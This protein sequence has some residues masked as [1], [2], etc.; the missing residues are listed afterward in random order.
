VEQLRAQ[1][2]D[3]GER[4][5]RALLGVWWWRWGH[6]REALDAAF[7]PHLSLFLDLLP[8]SAPWGMYWLLCIVQHLAPPAGEV[9]PILLGLLDHFRSDSPE[10]VQRRQHLLGALGK[11]G[12]PSDADLDRIAEIARRDKGARWHAILCLG[13]AART[14]PRAVELLLEFLDYR[15]D[16]NYSAGRVLGELRHKARP[17]LPRLI[18]LVQGRDPAW[19]VGALDAIANMRKLAAAAAPAV[20]AAARD[21]DKAVRTKALYALSQLGPEV[22]GALRAAR[23]ALDEPDREIRESAL[24]AMNWLTRPSEEARAVVRDMLRHADSQV[25]RFALFRMVDTGFDLPEVLARLEGEIGHRTAE[26]RREAVEALG[27]VHDVDRYR[28]YQRQHRPA[29][30]GDRKDVRPRAPATV[31]LLRRALE[32]RDSSVRYAAVQALGKLGAAARAAVPRL[33]KLTE[34][35]DVLVEYAA[36]AALK[37]IEAA[38]E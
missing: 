23:E 36:R 26:R 4:V 21:P 35:T 37:K 30:L 38:S 8:R 20:L 11:I 6:P 15:C 12:L 18:E 13:A 3:L 9:G 17:A 24:Q 2:P 19:R 5:G 16:I 14:Y 33:R 22:E 10:E 34:D 7:R 27:F 32:D 1:P 25:R 28:E 29:E 31:P